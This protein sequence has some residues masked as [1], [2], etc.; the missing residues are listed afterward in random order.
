VP[1]LPWRER[2]VNTI[3]HTI[4]SRAGW[5]ALGTIVFVGFF[6]AFLPQ[7]TPRNDPYEFVVDRDPATTFYYEFKKIFEKEDFFVIAY[8]QEDLFTERRLTELKELT[9]TLLNLEGVSDVVS[10][11][12]VAD[13]RGTEDMFDADDFL[14]DI[15]SSPTALTALRQRALANPLYQKVLVSDDGQTTAIV[16]FTPYVASGENHDIDKKRGNFS[17]L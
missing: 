1:P 16:V 15:P 8:H 10:L 3:A 7:L 17:T 5:V 12:N 9:E 14:R 2:F 6:G 13:M 11:A 4:S